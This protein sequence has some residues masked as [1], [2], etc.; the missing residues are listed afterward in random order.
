MKAQLLYNE[1][2]S[3]H[4][5]EGIAAIED[6]SLMNVTFRT[7]DPVK[8]GEFLAYAAQSGMVGING[9]R[10]TSLLLFD[11]RYCP[12]EKHVGAKMSSRVASQ[13]ANDAEGRASRSASDVDARRAQYMW[14]M[15]H[16]NREITFLLDERDVDLFPKDALVTTPQQW[17]VIK[18]CGRPIAFNET[19]V[20]SA[21]SKIDANIASL[22]ISTATTN[23]T[24]VPEELLEATVQKLSSTLGCPIKGSMAKIVS[25]ISDLSLVLFV[26]V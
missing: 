17:R 23:C 22:N 25:M 12:L 21:M 5:F 7:N 24:L 18:L 20:V 10:T 3:N 11:E 6:R 15:W 13:D 9:Y 26:V 14:G 2:D 1:I 4:I 19:G 16:Q 8:E